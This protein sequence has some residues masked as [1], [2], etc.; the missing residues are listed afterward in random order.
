MKNKKIS[1]VQKKKKKN[2]HKTRERGGGEGGGELAAA[3][4]NEGCSPED[5]TKQTP[6]QICS[7]VALLMDD[8]F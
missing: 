2:V 6:T 8:S 3:L 4:W 1:P 5:K 7:F